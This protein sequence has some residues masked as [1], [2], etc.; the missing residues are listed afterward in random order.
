MTR[1]QQKVALITGA[2]KG[3]GREVARRLAR[4]GMTVLVG[5]RDRGRGE[6]AVAKLR[7]AAPAVHLVVLDVAD[8]TSVRHAGDEIRERFGRLDV[9]VNNA[10][11][12]IGSA[13]PSQQSLSA[14]RELLALNAIGPLA[15]I[16]ACLPLLRQSP[17]ARIVN[18]STS[19]SS[20]SVGAD[21]ESRLSPFA[22]YFGYFASKTALN[23]VTVGVANEL[24]SQGAKVN[25]AC[26]GY[27]ATDL[28]GHRGVRTV[29]QGAEIILRLATLPEEGPTGAFF[30]EAGVV[31]W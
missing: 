2:N 7:E 8:E 27:V 20:L 18:V 11:G 23:A 29:E 9:L 30:D 24:R 25:A 14:F 12:A 15:V 5:A 26:P 16:Q 1:H 13:R 4:E 21:P 22:D 17:A 3:I 10:G 28:N 6:S 31:P 19:L